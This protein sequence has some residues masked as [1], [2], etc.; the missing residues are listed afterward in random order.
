MAD[1][2]DVLL[3]GLLKATN[4][5]LEDIQQKNVDSIC[6]ALE[7][8]Q[9]VLDELAALP[10]RPA[11]TPARRA[12]A[13]RILTQNKKADAALRELKS[14]YQADIG[15]LSNKFKVLLEYQKMNYNL[16][17]GQLYDRKK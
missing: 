15:D 3:D 16:S 9:S 1:N 11:L 14:V 13:D 2:F 12:V 5:L 4:D 8:R 6:T 7:Q 10:G 17:A